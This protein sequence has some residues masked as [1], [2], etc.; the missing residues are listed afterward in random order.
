MGGESYDDECFTDDS[1][2]QRESTLLS[3][4]EFSASSR[5]S[6]VVPVSPDG[7]SDAASEIDGSSD[8]EPVTP[9]APLPPQHLRAE[10][11]DP[12]HSFRDSYASVHDYYSH[13]HSR[14]P[15]THQPEYRPDTPFMDTIVAVNSQVLVARGT[16]GHAREPSVIRA[17]PKQG[18]MGEWNQEDM[19]DVISKLRSLK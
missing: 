13:S 15:S 3:P 17:E 18:W 4:M 1:N 5:H 10:V 16:A 2:A 11:L 9:V 8:N 12:R 14:G 19:R 6:S 7:Q